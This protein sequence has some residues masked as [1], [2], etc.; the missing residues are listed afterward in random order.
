MKEAL[1]DSIDSILMCFWITI[2]YQW[3][4]WSYNTLLHLPSLSL[5]LLD[6]DIG[7]QWYIS[8]LGDYGP[9]SRGDN[10][11][12]LLLMII[13]IY[14]IPL[15]NIEANVEIAGTR[16]ESGN[17]QL[18]RAVK[19]KVMEKPI[20]L[21]SIILYHILCLFSILSLSYRDAVESSLYVSYAYC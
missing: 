1:R 21:W 13:K 12:T 11:Y 9:R 4:D 16:V 5:F 18:G 8:W 17:K 6:W 10:W 7:Y 3:S 15:D 14:C 20:I 2:V 19:H